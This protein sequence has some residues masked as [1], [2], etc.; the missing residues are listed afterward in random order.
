MSSSAVE[1]LQILRML[2]NLTETTIENKILWDYL[3]EY[4]HYEN[5]E[6]MSL[7]EN[8]FDLVPNYIMIMADEIIKQIMK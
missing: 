1:K 6:M 8:K 3:T 7:D 2:V 4:Y 5:N